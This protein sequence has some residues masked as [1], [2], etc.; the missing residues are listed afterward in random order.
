[1]LKDPAS[2]YSPGRRGQI[3]LKLKS[4]LPTLD[5]VVTAAEYGHGKRRTVLSD[6]TFA[7]WDRNPAEPG[8]TLVNVVKAYIGVTDEVIDQLTQTFLA[9]SRGRAGR[10]HLVE[11][12]IV[13]EVAADQI[14][15][16]TRHAS[17]YALRFP[18]IKR[19]RWDKGPQEVDLLSR[20]KEVFESSANFARATVEPTP[21]TPEATLFDSI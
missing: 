10:V 17:G 2:P 21:A 7:V 1:M 5:C 13:L 11:P 4:H 3:W 9:L 15:K 19:I 14:Q 20:V 6:Y 8:A 12:K 16:S 18:R